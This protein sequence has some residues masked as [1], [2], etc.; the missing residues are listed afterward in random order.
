VG[1]VHKAR[2]HF[3]CFLVLR[4]GFSAF[5]AHR[6]TER[7]GLFAFADVLPKF[8]PTV[9]T[10]LAALFEGHVHGTGIGL[11]AGFGRCT[12]ES[13]NMRWIGRRVP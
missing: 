9:R 2:H 6:H 5:T 3:E 12:N 10:Q 8:L 13:A 4:F 1:A 7:K 11:E